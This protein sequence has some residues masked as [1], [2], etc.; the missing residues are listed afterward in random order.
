[1]N[2]SK[3]NLYL[4]IKKFSSRKKNNKKT[5]HIKNKKKF[6]CYL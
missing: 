5:F 2:D 3:N 6:Q 4:L 1:M